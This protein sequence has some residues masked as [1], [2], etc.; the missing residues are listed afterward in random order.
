MWSD[1][2]AREVYTTGMEMFGWTRSVSCTKCSSIEP[3]GGAEKGA[4]KELENEYIVLRRKM[5]PMDTGF[6]YGSL[7]NIFA[8][9][10]K[11]RKFNQL[12]LR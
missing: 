10:M 8:V 7:M 1:V 5:H 3:I 9:E 12:C 11:S 4:L 6:D 2:I